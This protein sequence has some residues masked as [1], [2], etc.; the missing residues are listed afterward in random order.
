MDIHIKIVQRLIYEQCPEFKELEIKPVEKCG[1]DN[2]TFHLGDDMIIRLPSGKDYAMQAK[3]ENTWL[4]YLANHLSLPIS[5]PLYLGKGTEYYPYPW[6]ILKYLDGEILSYDNIESMIKFAK[7]LSN[8][9]GEFQQIP[10]ENGPV[11]GKHNFYRGGNL[12]V[13]HQETMDALNAL[14]DQI[15]TVKLLDLWH[16]ALDSNEHIE[17]VWVHGD[18]APG[19]LLVQNGHLCG[20]IDFG[21][22]GVGDPACDYAMAWTFFEEKSRDVFLQGISSQMRNRAMGWALWKALI[23]YESDEDERRMNAR[24]VIEQILKDYN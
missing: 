16:L 8:F 22:L 9:L 14:T 15:D 7:E 4:P 12:K 6:S 19:N 3:K 23:T 1:H 13:Y 21:I 24:Y 5:K 20:V 10:C 18:I 2:Q 11:A 17:N